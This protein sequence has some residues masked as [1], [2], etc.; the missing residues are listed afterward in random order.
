MKK[1]FMILVAA[2][3]VACV[4]SCSKSDDD[5]SSEPSFVTNPTFNMNDLYGTWKIEKI[6]ANGYD[7]YDFDS[8]VKET[9]G[10]TKSTTAT[11]NKNGS[12]EG[13]GYFGN[14][15]GTYDVSGDLITTYI[16]GSVYYRYKVISESSSTC[17]L[18]MSDTKSS[19]E[20]YLICNK[21]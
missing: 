4:S 21:K 13:Y 15:S 14:G 9:Y 19:K 6:S 5:N 11:F 3:L 7:Y 20:L 12:Y 18:L 1:Y 17:K 10:Y 16:G 2:L 8:F